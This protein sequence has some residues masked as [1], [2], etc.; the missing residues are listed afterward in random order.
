ML[1]LLVLYYGYYGDYTHYY[2]YDYYTY[3]GECKRKDNGKGKC[4]GR[5]KQIRK[6]KGNHKG[7]LTADLHNM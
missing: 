2:W 1:L 5:G 6:C 3:N 4:I 7:K